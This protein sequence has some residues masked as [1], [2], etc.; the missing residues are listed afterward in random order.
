MSRFLNGP[1]KPSSLIHKRGARVFSSSVTGPFRR[2]GN[3]VKYELS[4][5][6]VHMFDASKE[7]DVFLSLTQD[8][9]QLKTHGNHTWM[10]T[11]PLPD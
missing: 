1:F 9:W 8:S 5:E 2:F 3:R 6:D 4:D 10:G 7:G 11:L